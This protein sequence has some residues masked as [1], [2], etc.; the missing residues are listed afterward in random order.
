MHLT[1]LNLTLKIGY[2]GKRYC[3]FYVVL[4]YVDPAVILPGR[5]LNSHPCF[6]EA[7]VLSTLWFRSV[8]CDSG[9]GSRMCVCAPFSGLQ[10]SLC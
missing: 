9:K 2:D 10:E 1:L 4:C 6:L 7:P 5:G 8:T 3:I